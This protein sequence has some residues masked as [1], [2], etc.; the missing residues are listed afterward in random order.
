MRL[1]RRAV[2]RGAEIVALR[3]HERFVAELAVEQPIEAGYPEDAL[4][5]LA[6][7]FQW[8]DDPPA[9]TLAGLSMRG[10]GI[11]QRHHARGFEPLAGFLEGDRAA[12]V[13]G[14]DAAD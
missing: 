14:F 4:R 7:I 10:G 9:L 8:T 12:I 3:K 6:W 1:D 13:I 2:T 11:D 5:R